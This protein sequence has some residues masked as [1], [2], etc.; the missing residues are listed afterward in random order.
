MFSLI[1]DQGTI[2]CQLDGKTTIKKQHLR[3]LTVEENSIVEFIKNKNR[4]HQGISKK[5]ATN[6]VIDY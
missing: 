2:D 5:K 1:K 3:I 4:C 6:L